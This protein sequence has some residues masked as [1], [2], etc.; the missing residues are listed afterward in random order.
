MKMYLSNVFL[1]KI[2][3]FSQS[4]NS[5]LGAE[6]YGTY[7]VKLSKY[8]HLRF[9]HKLMDVNLS[10]GQMV[11][12]NIETKR[13]FDNRADLIIGCDGSNWVVRQ[14]MMEVPG[15]NISQV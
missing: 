11:L 7:K 13:V 9:N 5:Q 3:P 1:N 14:K 15:F 2:W 6:K 12:M 8:G 4:N 10:T